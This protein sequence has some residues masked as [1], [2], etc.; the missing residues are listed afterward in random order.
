MS[1]F[2]YFGAKIE[3]AYADLGRTMRVGIFFEK[4]H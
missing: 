3:T 2:C 4:K 1:L